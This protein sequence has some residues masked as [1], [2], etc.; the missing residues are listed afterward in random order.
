MSVRPVLL[1]IPREDAAFAAYARRCLD[2]DDVRFDPLR[3][4]AAL[5]RFHTRAA[6]YRKAEIRPF[7][8]EEIW[9]VYRDGRAVTRDDPEWW[10]RPDGAHAT[11]DESGRF[12]EA[13]EAA[14]ALVGL[15][16]GELVGRRYD[17]LI[18]GP[19]RPA[20]IWEVL[21]ATGSV[22]SVFDF[23]LPDGGR[24]IIEYRIEAVG[25]GSYESRWRELMTLDREQ[26]ARLQATDTSS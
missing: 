6:V 11:L 14:C 20:W 22:R 12:T 16:P 13:N 23:P 15:G 10:L 21:A 7:G 18:P 8:D 17:D 1:T 2:D 25:S 19:S 9:Y 3:L 26:V 5:R 4:Q 24:R